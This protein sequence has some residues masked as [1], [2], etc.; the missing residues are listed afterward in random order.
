MDDEDYVA[1]NG[2]SS[3]RRMHDSYRIMQANNVERES[4]SEEAI[5]SVSFSPFN[6]PLH[7]FFLFLRMNI[8]S[9]C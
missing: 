3:R 7:H 5:I 4:G 1:Q 6:F 9:A 2:L 8:A